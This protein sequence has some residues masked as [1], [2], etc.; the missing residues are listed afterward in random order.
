[1]N[2]CV[3]SLVEVDAVG[4]VEPAPT[5]TPAAPSLA[6]VE[7]LDVVVLE[8]VAVTVSV[9]VSST[10]NPAR[11]LHTMPFVPGAIVQTARTR[12]EG[13]VS[14][15]TAGAAAEAGSDA[16]RPWSREP[17]GIMCGSCS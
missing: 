2:V 15:T 11:S 3:G 8:G 12:P 6:D 1:M 7:L 10:G 5:W 14:V 16:V 9:H 4:V 17:A 13:S